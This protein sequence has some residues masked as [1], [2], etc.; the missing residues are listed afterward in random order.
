MRSYALDDERKY[1]TEYFIDYRLFD[2]V[3]SLRI[4]NSE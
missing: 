2:D 3:T 1:S 4:S